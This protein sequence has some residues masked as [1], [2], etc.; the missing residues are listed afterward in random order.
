MDNFDEA[1]N[2]TESM[3]NE[4][5]EV[6]EAPVEEAPTEAVETKKDEMLAEATNIADQATQVAQQQNEQLS[7]VMGEHNCRNVKG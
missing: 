2:A 6:E 1:R 4:T 3:F 5:P 7:Q